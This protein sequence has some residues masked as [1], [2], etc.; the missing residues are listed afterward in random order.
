MFTP[1]ATLGEPVPGGGGILFV[2]DFEPCR[3]NARGQIAYGA[4]ISSGGE[5]VFLLGNKRTSILAL[6]GAQA[7]D[8][9][10]YGGGFLAPISINDAGDEVFPFLREPS[11]PFAGVNAGLY[12]YAH[13]TGAVTALVLPGDPIPGAED[14]FAGIY[15]GTVINNCGQVAFNGIVPANIGPGAELFGLG[16]GMFVRD[17]SGRL[18]KVMR[19]GDPAPG[20]DI[21]DLGRN[22]YLN[23]AG[24]VIF[25]AHLVADPLIR[26]G[27]P[28]WSPFGV[29]ATA[30]A[31]KT[32]D[33]QMRL[34]VRRGDPAPGGGVFL[35]T[36]GPV[37]NNAGQ[38]LF[39]AAV[40]VS[41]QM[42]VLTDYQGNLFPDPNGVGVPSSYGIFFYSQGTVV[43]IARP[44]D[45]MPGG[46]TL[47]VTG[48]GPMEYGINNAGVVSFT[49]SL[50]NG[51]ATGLYTWSDGVLSLVAK[52][53]TEIPGIGTVK[54]LQ[55]PQGWGGIFPYSGAAINERGQIVFQ[56]T[57]VGDE[58]GTMLL[59]TPRNATDG[60]STSPS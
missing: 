22:V 49:A 47:Y 34:L 6:S 35:T 39:V 32:G 17:N 4:D 14:Q 31:R 26:L 29:A 40:Q 9:A 5:G 23:D 54:W 13:T 60:V 21:F 59:A 46:G 51:A 19:P 2:N 7:P 44:G 33:G 18:S 58:R 42:G 3:I 12:G 30:I 25:E 1:L 53:G 15:Y 38:F 8:G 37:M 56:I 10:T 20:G 41:A 43:A 55:N 16:A 48:G 57:T 36:W 24:D 45:P 27:P 52:T 11:G 50:D 28:Q